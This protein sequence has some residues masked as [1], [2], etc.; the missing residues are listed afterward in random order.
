MNKIKLTTTQILVAIVLLC[1]LMTIQ[2][3]SAPMLRANGK[4]AFTSDRD[5]NSEIYLMN[6][7]GTNQTRLTNNSVRDDY[8]T[9]SPDG[10]KIAFVRQSGDTY[11][12]NLMNADGTNVR[13]ITTFSADSNYPSSLSWSP[14]GTKIA[15]VDSTDIYTINVDGGNRINLTNGQSINYEPSWS[16]DSSRI[17]FTRYG[18]VPENY[19][20]IYTMTSNGSD[21]RKITTSPHGY[22]GGSHSPDWSPDGGRIAL[23][24]PG[25]ELDADHIALINPDGTNLQFILYSNFGYVINNPNWSPDGAKIVFNGINFSNNISQ[26]WAINRN[27]SGLT[28]L[29]NTSPNNFHPDWQPAQISLT[30]SNI[31]ELYAAVN[32]SANADSQ[33]VIAAGVYM[34]SVNDPNGAARPNG[35]RLELQENMSLLGITDNRAAV[36]I[37]A[38]NL[39]A[40]SYLSPL[41]GAIRIGRGSNAI[42]WLTA[43]NAVSGASNIQS[44]LIFPGTAFV[45]VA[46]VASSGSRRGINIL[47]IGA[48][49][50]NAVVEAD[51]IDN[52]LFDN[53]IA[54]GEGMRI[55]NFAGANGGSVVARL[56]GNRSHGNKQGLLVVDNGAS[57]ASISVVSSGDRFYENG[58]GTNIFGALSGSPTTV[59]GNTITFEAHGSFFTDN[60]G[61]TEFDKGGLVV[62]GGENISV[63]NGTSNNKVTVNL[64]GCQF[65]NNQLADLYAVGARSN[66]A[67]IGTPG[68]NNTVRVALHGIGSLTEFRADSI[69]A[70]PGSGNSLTVSRQPIGKPDDY[71][72]DGRDDL[73][74]FRPSSSTWYIQ[75]GNAANFYGVPFGLATDKLVPADYDGDGKTDIAV[76]RAGIWYLQR[77]Q[78]G[79]LGIAFGDGGDIPQPADF[80][81]DGRAEIAVW[82]PSNGVWYVY[83]LATNQFTSFQLG[84]SGDKPVVGDYDGD[85]RADYAVFRQSDGIWIIQQS[86]AGLMQFVFGNGSFGDGN[87]A[88]VP[89]DYDGDGKTDLAIFQPSGG[90]SGSIWIIRLSRSNTPQFVTWGLG[91]DA[92]VP[93][94]YD[95]DGK[96]D[97]AVYRNGIWYI[98]QTSNG[99]NYAY[100]G[101]GGDVPTNQVQ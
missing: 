2:I 42:E 50:A 92:L 78:T 74:V 68:T 59:N 61:T 94:D 23:S 4:I 17:A 64:F 44:D 40:A 21:V 43:R 25:D 71:D 97:I 73:T 33:I 5:G 47:N 31:E 18:A 38:M 60:N 57:N 16:P 1:G 85:G 13:Q 6:A 12:I 9:W 56:S 62:G 14:D 81:G 10:R 65:S 76:Y 77:S 93:A 45:R 87:D 11:S 89:A 66:P 95:G 98:R 84:T 36:V 86:T 54:I 20:E 88:P 15:F 3:Q 51:I 41:T 19:G 37:D 100:F 83:N 46:H 70:T 32:N 7:D 48:A 28:Q 58:A 91:T 96:A 29:T 69:P 30:V 53:I 75:P 82:R 79:F 55:G 39:P 99:I 101:A 67:S 26:I 80:D 52:D 8:P 72:G 63:P 22:T 49:A 24:M 90:M 35:G 34:L 27:G